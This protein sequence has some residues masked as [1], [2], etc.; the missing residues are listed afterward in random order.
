LLKP[1]AL[2]EKQRTRAAIKNILA[3]TYSRPGKSLAERIARELVA[4]V[5]GEKTGAVVQKESVHKVAAANRSNIGVR[6]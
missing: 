4:I 5:S 2:N 3:A 1:E 6:V